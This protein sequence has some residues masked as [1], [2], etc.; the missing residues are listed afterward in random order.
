MADQTP[1]EVLPVPF[2]DELDSTASPAQPDA[3]WQDVDLSTDDQ[4]VVTEP[5]A[6]DLSAPDLSAPDLSAPEQSAVPGHV[7]TEVVTCPECGTSATVAL[8]RRDARDF[9]PNCDFP[10]FWTPTAVVRDMLGEA[11]QDALR[12]LPGTLGRATVASQRCPH[13]A[14]P[15]ALSAQVCVRCGR[16]MQIEAPPPPAVPVYVPPPPPEPVY[17]EPKK[18]VAWWVWA[19]VALAVVVAVVVVL[20]VTGTLG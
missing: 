3:S 19:L 7:V 13:C 2:T 8:N 10:L 9:C 1:T 12:R 16:S 20:I 15:N 18:G 5:S 11:S 4:P 6:P 14:E 17:V